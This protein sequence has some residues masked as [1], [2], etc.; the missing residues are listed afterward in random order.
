[1]PATRK[2]KVAFD[3][4]AK[5]VTVSSLT[6]GFERIYYAYTRHHSNKQNKNSPGSRAF[7]RFAV[8]RLPGINAGPYRRSSGDADTGRNSDRHPTAI[9]NGNAGSNPPAN[10]HTLPAAPG[11][12]L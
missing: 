10:R 7:G 1:L 9:R 12:Q 8:Q 5:S 6:F 3:F 11:R 4:S 2:P